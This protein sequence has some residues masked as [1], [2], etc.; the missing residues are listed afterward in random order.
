[1]SLVYYSQQVI[2]HCSI[3]LRRE[4]RER[5]KNKNLVRCRLEHL[6]VSSWRFYTKL[7][8][9]ATAPRLSWWLAPPSHGR[10]PCIPTTA[11]SPWVRWGQPCAAHGWG[12]CPNRVAPVHGSSSLGRQKGEEGGEEEDD[13][14]RIMVVTG[15]VGAPTILRTA[16]ISVGPRG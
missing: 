5:S 6:P 9:H 2:K 4:N 12:S 8:A 3:S 13:E 16:R 10:R 7:S 14:R 11:A 15:P 1:L